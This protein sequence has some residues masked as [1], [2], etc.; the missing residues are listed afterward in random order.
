[1]KRPRRRA[2]RPDTVLAPV[3][4]P[5]EEIYIKDLPACCLRSLKE[6]VVMKEERRK[7][8][9]RCGTC[10]REWWVTSSLD[11]RVLQSFVTHAGARVGGGSHPAA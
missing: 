11:E 7:L 8:A 6:S 5:R 2:L 4:R 10:G 1:M 9:L 3:G